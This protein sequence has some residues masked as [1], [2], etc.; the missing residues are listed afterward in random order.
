MT[1]PFVDL[2]SSHAEIRAEL[3][4]AA[5]RVVDSSWFILGRELEAF[6]NA[7]ARY[8]QAQHCLGVGNGLDALHLILRG[9]GIGAGDEVVVPAH[10]FIATWLAATYA[11]ARPVAVDVDPATG[12]I[13]PRQLAAAIT[14][15]TRAIIAVHLYG[16]P[17]D[18]EAIRAII[19]KR[20]IKL[21]EDAAQAHGAGYKGR[22]AGSLGDAAAFSFYPT[23]NLGALGDGGAVVTS[24]DDLAAAVRRLRN[25]G[26]DTKY[27]HEVAGWNS[28]LDEIQA[29]FLS[30]K[31]PHLDRW[32]AARR[33]AARTYLNG[34]AGVP[35][36]ALPV[37]P[38][39]AEPVWHLFVIRCVERE[40]LR[41][42][43]SERG[44][45][46]AIHY[47][48]P[49]NRQGAYREAS[50]ARASLPQ[51]YAW[52]G[53]ALSLPMWP[54]VPAAQVVAAVRKC[55]SADPLEPS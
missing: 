37:V 33:L 54:G 11:G 38:A 51:A 9:Y 10:T 2:A 5:R 24:D 55:L 3:D 8:C 46:T 39:W 53:E 15:R 14:D 18:M 41:A 49:P 4:A 31:L 16:Q 7:F 12:N 21:I 23:K 47:P 34:L 52:A 29:A 40:R 45:E 50:P 28:R 26:S 6:E 20:N 42:Y 22:R 13:D 19:G 48:V 27:R 44:I 32:N 17:A 25:Y 43:L 1:L 36:L 30:A 35:G